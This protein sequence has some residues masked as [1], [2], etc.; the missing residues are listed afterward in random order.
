[1]TTDKLNYT[2]GEAIDVSF[3]FTNTGE[4]PLP[5]DW[6]GIYPCTDAEFDEFLAEVW[7]WTCDVKKPSE[8]TSAVN[9]GNLIFNKLPSYNDYFFKQKW[10][11]AP[12][13]SND[14][15]INRCFKAVLFRSTG[16]NGLIYSLQSIPVCQSSS[17]DIIETTSCPVRSEK[18]N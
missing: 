4:D 13:M 7:Q 14:G 3:D 9:S 1:M 5:D 8:C 11:V 18:L 15:V 12:Y 17:F 16:L 6:V 2:C 10:P